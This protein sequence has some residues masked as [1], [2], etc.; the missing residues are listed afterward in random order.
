V[1]RHRRFGVGQE[2][3]RRI[4]ASLHAISLQHG[5]PQDFST[6][7]LEEYKKN[8]GFAHEGDETPPKTLSLY[9]EFKYPG[10]AW[11]MAIDLNS[12]NGCNACVWR[13]SR[14]TT[15]Q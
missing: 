2:N 15:F 12:C 10:Y 13:A 1:A 7:T 14:K 5:R 4:F 11:G 3:R 9:Q 8:P 6:G